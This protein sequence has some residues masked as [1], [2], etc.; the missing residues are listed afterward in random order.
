MKVI[1]SI[2]YIFASIVL[3]LIILVKVITSVGDYG[4]GE[5]WKIESA[6]WK[7][8]EDE[9]TGKSIIV[10]D[11]YGEDRWWKN[12]KRWLKTVWKK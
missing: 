9:E 7:Y 4:Y 12:I 8:V 1:S 10:V 3:E 11:K 6:T 2:W 5:L